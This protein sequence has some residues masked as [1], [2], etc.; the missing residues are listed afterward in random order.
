VKL[1]AIAS[2]DAPSGA[3]QTVVVQQVRPHGGD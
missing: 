3:F 1:R 2:F